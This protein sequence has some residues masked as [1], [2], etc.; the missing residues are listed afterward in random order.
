MR[1]EPYQW[2]HIIA[3][4][5]CDH[6]VTRAC[7]AN[8]HVR[9]AVDEFQQLRIFQHIHTV[10]VAHLGGDRTRIGD[11]IPV[12]N[13]RAAPGLRQGRARFAAYV[14]ENCAYGQIAAWRQTHLASRVGELPDV[15]DETDDHC[16]P[17]VTHQFDLR[18]GACF[19][20][21]AR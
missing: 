17:Q 21:G 19:F 12:K 18:D 1:V 2:I 7:I 8:P 9:F 10:L 4:Q 14:S 16:H 15:F 20:A 3:V 13:A 6:H 5:R 11:A